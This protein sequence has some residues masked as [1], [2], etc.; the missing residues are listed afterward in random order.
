M[1]AA[2]RKRHSLFSGRRPQTVAWGRERRTTRPVN[3]EP[4]CPA[5]K[6]LFT[7]VLYNPLPPPRSP[8]A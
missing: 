1:A 2:H 4:G 8:G 3:R 6:P 7:P 5:T